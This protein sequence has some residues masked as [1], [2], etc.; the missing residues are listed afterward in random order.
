MPLSPSRSPVQGSVNL[1]PRF[2]GAMPLAPPR[3]APLGFKTKEKRQPIRVLALPGKT[4]TASGQGEVGGGG[5]L[6]T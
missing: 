5:V 6:G 1:F 2:P 3:A 4:N